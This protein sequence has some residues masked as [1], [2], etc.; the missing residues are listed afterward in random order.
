MAHSGN[1]DICADSEVEME[2]TSKDGGEPWSHM[3]KI[4]QSQA[5]SQKQHLVFRRH[6]ELCT[7][8]LLEVCW[9]EAFRCVKAT[10]GRRE[11]SS[12]CCTETCKQL[13]NLFQTIKVPHSKMRKIIHKWKTF[14]TAANLPK[15]YT[16]CRRLTCEMGLHIG[17]C[18]GELT[19]EKRSTTPLQRWQRRLRKVVV[20]PKRLISLV[21]HCGRCRTTWTNCGQQVSAKLLRLPERNGLHAKAWSK[22]MTEWS[23]THQENYKYKL[24]T[25]LESSGPCPY[26]NPTQ[27]HG[28]GK[29]LR[30]IGFKSTLP[31]SS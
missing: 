13:P 12:W 21:N 8:S 30:F 31:L 3:I 18:F 15:K 29:E 10:P 22:P 19:G 23:R 28:L 14:K 17:R 1:R 9:S 4:I 6:A 20:R 25:A 27:S 24:I 16:V 26:I 11:V 7:S 2:G 5:T